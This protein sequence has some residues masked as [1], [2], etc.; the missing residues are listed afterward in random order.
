MTTKLVLSVIVAVLVVI[1][2]MINIWAIRKIKEIE[3]SSPDDSN[4]S[5]IESEE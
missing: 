1:N 3:T 5:G 2:T 4:K